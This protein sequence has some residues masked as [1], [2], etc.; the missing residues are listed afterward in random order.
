MAN[1]ERKWENADED[2]PGRAKRNAGDV[3]PVLPGIQFEDDEDLCSLDAIDEDPD[4][5]HDEEYDDFDDDAFVAGDD[6][7]PHFD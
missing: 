6:F 4:D 1:R 3:S 5:W 7:D 2:S